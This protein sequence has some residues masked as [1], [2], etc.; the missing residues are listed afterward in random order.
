MRVGALV[1]FLP[2]SKKIS[3]SAAASLKATTA[4]KIV[5]WSIVRPDYPLGTWENLIGCRIGSSCS[6]R[7]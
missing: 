3:D 5:S 2:I 6:R 7:W 4:E 1:V